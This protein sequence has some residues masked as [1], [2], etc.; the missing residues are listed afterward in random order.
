MMNLKQILEIK[1]R[2]AAGENKSNIAKEMGI[3]WKTADKYLKKDD[4]N[5]TVEDYVKKTRSSKL[6]PYKRE[7]DELL[8][9]EAKSNYF[10]KQHLTATRVYDILGLITDAK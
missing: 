7:I 9:K 3:D 10:H 2:Y 6:D 4:F 5:E 8:E 1:E